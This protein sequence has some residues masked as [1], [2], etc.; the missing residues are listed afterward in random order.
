MR[1]T[2][3]PASVEPVE[4][5]ARV[6]MVLCTLLFVALATAGI[7]RAIAAKS[8]PREHVVKIENMAFS[9]AVLHV[10]TGERVVF[11]N[12]DLVPHTVTAK[13][14][15][16]FDSGTLQGGD[17]WTFTP[18]HAGTYHYVCTFHPMMKGSLVVR[19]R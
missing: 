13:T 4:L 15:P 18:P 16:A 9:P 19:P 2:F 10:L 1:N 3:K 11:R 7:T 6:A 5:R 17:E 12:L 8:S 14:A